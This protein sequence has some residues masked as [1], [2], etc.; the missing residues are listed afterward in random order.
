NYQH[1]RYVI[2]A[3]PSLIF[4]G[5][6]GMFMLAEAVKRNMWGRILTRAVGAAAALVFVYFA[7]S[8]G[9]SVY[10]ADVAIIEQEM[11]ASARWIAENIPA[12]ELLAI[13]D[14]GA[15][16]YFAPRPLLDVAGL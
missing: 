11:V 1:G 10:Q 5:V 16:G 7:V 13:H 14:I 8:V 9:P 2:P 6:T 15:V 4:A 12:D 3:L